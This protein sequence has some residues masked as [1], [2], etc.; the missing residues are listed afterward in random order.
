MAGDF[1]GMPWTRLEE[2]RRSH[3]LWLAFGLAVV[4]LALGILE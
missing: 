3:W 2:S 1:S 4:V